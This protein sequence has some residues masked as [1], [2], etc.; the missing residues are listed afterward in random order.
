MY[1]INACLKIFFIVLFLKGGGGG[2]M[3]D[4]GST[5]LFEPPFSF[6]LLIYAFTCPSQQILV[7]L[8]LILTYGYY[9]FKR[10]G[11]NQYCL[12]PPQALHTFD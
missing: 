5:D 7:M 4:G 1:L 8:V 12:E 6:W 2:F 3:W 10:G 9:F 11:F